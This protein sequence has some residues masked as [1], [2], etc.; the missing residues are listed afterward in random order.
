MLTFG[1]LPG[2]TAEWLDRE[3]ECHGA[4][5]TL[6]RVQSTPEDPFWVPGSTVDIDVRPTKD[7]LA[8]GVAGY[9]TADAHK[10]FERA[11]SFA[12]AKT[13]ATLP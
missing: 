6:G 5:L 2:E 3:L 7:G 10:I 12:K 13:R 11:Q 4:R 1:A 8:V 9:S